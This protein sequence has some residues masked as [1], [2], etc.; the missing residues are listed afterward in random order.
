VNEDGDLGKFWDPEDLA[1]A[2]QARQQ[3]Q[4]RLDGA[5]GRAKPNGAGR[6][7]PAVATLLSG[8]SIV[9]V[10]YQWLWPDWLAKGKLEIVAGGV[11]AGKT[12]I[13]IGFA[14]TITSAGKWPDNS[15]AVPGDVIVWSGEDSPA[16]T[17]LPRFL[18]AGGI[19]EKIHFVGPVLV[20]GKKRAFNPSSDMPALAEAAQGVEHLSMVI[21]DPVVMMVAGDSHKNTEVRRGLQPLV[22]L[23]ADREV[24]A[25]GI[26]HLTK[27]SAGRDPIERL[28]GSLAFGAGPRLVMM[29]AKPL[30][31][32]QPRRLV[33]VKSNIGPD[34][35][36]FEYSLAQAALEGH[37]GLYGQQAV[38][39]NPLYGTAWDLL[40]SV[41]MPQGGRPP[42][43]RGAAAEFLMGLLK[44]KPM[45]SQEVQGAAKDAGLAWA[46]VRRACEDLKIVITRIGGSDGHWQWELPADLKPGDETEI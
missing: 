1:R 8:T 4:E 17:L 42:K 27:G 2:E 16:D 18:A 28:T 9:P 11:G 20:N 3:Q 25:L 6:S 40:N 14:A 44:E 21:V 15:R 5:G 26:T 31:P 32:Y 12:T 29:A 19:R 22:D 30:D 23:A 36:G 46:T 35:D 41:E 38:W 7:S 45:P 24:L 37:E 10:Q 43:E 34:G 33:R 39:G 13:A